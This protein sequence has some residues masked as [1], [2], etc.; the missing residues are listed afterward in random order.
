VQKPRRGPLVAGAILFGAAYAASVSVAASAK[1][2]NGSAYMLVPLIGPI[3]AGSA[4]GHC[5]FSGRDEDCAGP[6]FGSLLLLDTLVQLSGATLVIVGLSHTRDVLLR[7]D[8]AGVTI[9][10]QLDASRGRGLAIV[11]VF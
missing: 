7:N 1:L 3:A 2:E 9:V 4:A 11:G 6:F 8:L 5:N 10:P